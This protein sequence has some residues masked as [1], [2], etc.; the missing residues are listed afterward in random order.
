MAR[1]DSGRPSDSPGAILEDLVETATE[2]AGASAA[3][4]T[5]TARRGTPLGRFLFSRA[6]PRLFWV[7]LASLGPGLIAANAG[8]DAGGIATYSQAGAAYG[9]S[10]LWV[11]P[12]ILVSLSVIQEMAARMGAA[13][14]KGLSDLIR[15]NFSIHITAVVLLALLI[16]NGMTVITEFI[17]IAASVD[18]VAP[19]AQVVAVP[20]IT[21]AL[22]LMVV[23][24]SY[25][26]VE[27]V[28]LF[29]TLVFFAYPVSALLAHPDW[30]EA[31][32]SLVVPNL[33]MGQMYLI[34]VVALIGTSIT[35]YMQ[36]YVQSAIAEKG[37][38]PRDYLPE[39][40]GVYVGS[41]FAMLVAAFIV[42][43]TAAT[44]YPNSN[45]Q[46]AAQAA[47][48]LAPVAGSA[49]KYLFAIG[50]FGASML[51]AAVLPLA[52]AYSITEAFGLEKGVSMGF[53]QAPVFMG[54]FTGLMAIGAFIA[55]FIPLP[56]I[57]VLVFIQ[58]IDCLLLPFVLFTI[59]R[60]ANNRKLMGTMA[61]GP[62]YNVVARTA[63]VV[64]TVLSLF[65][66]GTT[67]LGLFGLG[68]GA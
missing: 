50:L 42:I 5:G 43:T 28:F 12:L 23:T 16:A 57:K 17:G 59:L 39:R 67:V 8:N 21:A 48:A 11:F 63:A 31:A 1:N 6:R 2:S 49:D 66:V 29:M 44:L 27:R 34:T 55:A 19:H 4:G 54:I 36:V 26:S 45:I 18:L 33:H 64:V 52:T 56:V 30:G 25:S 58:V 20:L 40:I 32:R 13:T 61:N 9:Y 24:R 38:T 68:P 14:G 35:P 7:V 62:I 22:W 46:T 47:R 60:L 53:R 10:L 41:A 65:L 51:A 37:V 3:P 15:E